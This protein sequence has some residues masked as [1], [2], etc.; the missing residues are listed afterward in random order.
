MKI[1]NINKNKYGN[2]YKVY[3]E[4]DEEHDLS[5]EQIVKYKIKENTE[6]NYDKFKEILFE[7]NK[8]E[9]FNKALDIISFKDNTTYEIR[10]KLYKKGYDDIIISDVLEKLKEYNFI[11]D[12]K[13]A[14]SYVNS[15]LTYKKYGKNKIIYML[16]QRG[17][18][19]S[20]ISNLNFNNDLEFE[21]AK[22]VFYKKLSSLDK[23]DNNK[24]KEKLYRHLSSKGYS[25]EV[26][27]KLLKDL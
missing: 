3:L 24:K 22:N 10:N 7:D 26:I 18:S 13:Y 5:I 2:S 12:N 15:C 8:K 19:S 21:T 27:M 16:K 23:Y 17:I 14:Q 11:D 6:I 25:S 1:I 20:I 4:N 9:A